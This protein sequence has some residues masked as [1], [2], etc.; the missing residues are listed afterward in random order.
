LC[1]DVRYFTSEQLYRLSV[2]VL[3]PRLADAMPRNLP[4]GIQ[5]YTVADAL[6]RDVPGTLRH[7]RP[8]GYRDVE[9]AGFLGLTAMQFREEIDAA[10]PQCHSAHLVFNKNDPDPIFEDAHA[11]GAHYVVSSAMLPQ[12]A[13][14]A[15]GATTEDYKQMAERLNNL[16]KKAKQAGLQYAYHN[17][18][19][20]FTEFEDG[21]IG[22][23]VLLTSTDPD[24]VAFELDCGWM[25]SAGF[26]PVQYFRKYPH[27]FRMLHI[28]DFVKGSKISTSLTK[29]RPQGTELGRGQIDYKP[30]LMAALQAGIH[31]YYVEQEPPFLDM[32]SLEAAK[33]DYDYYM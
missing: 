13:P 2:Y 14:S 22:Y 27:R 19:V 11:L 6:Q 18:N 12:R 17:H 10:G 29:E 4:L 21:G 31:D 16:G 5:L 24:L 20:E 26:N 33:V 28:K 15:S 9:T 8:I 3:R 25:V 23:D 1:R 30:I 32:T 7:L